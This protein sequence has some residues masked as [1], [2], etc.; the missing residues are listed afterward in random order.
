MNIFPNPPP[1]RRIQKQNSLKYS[2]DDDLTTISSRQGIEKKS[3]Y[4]NLRHTSH[5]PS[6]SIKQLTIKSNHIGLNINNPSLT[7]KYFFSEP[8]EKEDTDKYNNLTLL[9]MKHI[10]DMRNNVLT[11]KLLS[12][13]KMFLATNTSDTSVNNANIILFGPSGSGKSSFIRT[14]YRAVYGTPFLPPEAINKLIIK[15]T[16]QNEGTLCFTRL[17]LKEESNNS[18]GIVICDTRGHIWM[19]ES[20]KEQ[21]K[22][23]IEGKVKDDIEIKQEENRSPLLLWE[24][25]KKDSELFPKEIFNSKQ[26]GIDSLPHCVV[27]VFDGSIDDI[28]DQNDEKFYRDLVNIAY[29]RGI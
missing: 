6:T 20:E 9:K 10:E 17:H 23:I 28:I 13:K 1:D 11:Y 12:D 14:L 4:N 29:N 2:Q 24:F 21:F 15:E 8:T 25:W 7:Q 5:G 27:I 26:P 3:S 18:S 16:D 19:N 22:V